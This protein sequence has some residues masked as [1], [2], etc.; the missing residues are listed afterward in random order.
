MSSHATRV[1]FLHSIRATGTVSVPAVKDLVFGLSKNGH[2]H[3]ALRVI[4]RYELTDWT[5][6]VLEGIRDSRRGGVPRLLLSQLDH[7]TDRQV[8]F[9][10][11]IFSIKGI[12]PQS[13]F[14]PTFIPLVKKTVEQDPSC[15][16]LAI[17]ALRRVKSERKFLW[18][19]YCRLPSCHDDQTIT[20]N[21]CQIAGI[22]GWGSERVDKILSRRSAN[23]TYSCA[24]MLVKALS[25]HPGQTSLKNLLYATENGG[26]IEQE[27]LLSAVIGYYAINNQFSDI[28]ELIR[29]IP[30][31]SLSITIF[32]SILR[33]A[34]EDDFFRYFSFMKN[35]VGLQ[36]SPVMVRKGVDFAL[37][38]KSAKLL[39]QM[40]QAAHVASVPLEAT[41][42]TRLDSLTNSFKVPVR[43]RRR[44]RELLK[45]IDTS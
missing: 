16:P 32:E 35:E 44:I 5:D 13:E 30:P 39:V 1:A 41:Q 27:P 11:E 19:M 25:H 21:M 8:L 18:L 29:S 10:M 23:L 36:P 42:V 17:A 28:D 15:I 31:S 14:L 7:L 26:K 40:L 4:Q 2:V 33:Y 6:A 20:R 3:D 43:V 24:A 37:E 45:L 12:H 9:L 22:N 34:K 38:I